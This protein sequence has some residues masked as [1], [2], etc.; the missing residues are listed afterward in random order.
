MVEV[1]T[2]S[3]QGK[4]HTDL[5]KLPKIALD[6]DF[7][8]FISDFPNKMGV[9]VEHEHSVVG[10]NINLKIYRRKKVLYA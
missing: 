9:P 3:D 5:G 4:P 10:S 7:L 2:S 6:L 1:G 8:G